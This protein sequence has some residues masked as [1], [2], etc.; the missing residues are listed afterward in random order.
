MTDKTFTNDI[1]ISSRIRLARNLKNECFPSMA[2]DMQL[3]NVSNLV[4]D[5][6]A[7]SE[8]LVSQKFRFYE[9]QNM[10]ETQR[11]SLAESRLISSELGKHAHSGAMINDENSMSIMINE[12]DHIRIQ[13]IT[14]GF[15]LFGAYRKA[16]AADDILQD[17]LDIAFSEKYGFLTCCPTNLGTGMRAGVMVHI[18]AIIMQNN[19][20]NIIKIAT[21]SG[22]EIRGAYGE[23]SVA[24]G[25]L[26]QISNRVSLGMN[27]NEIVHS[28]HEFT[29]EVIKTERQARNQLL[30]TREDEIKNE[31]HRAYGILTHAHMISTEEAMKLLSLLRLGTDVNLIDNVDPKT[32]DRLMTEIQPA[33][34]TLRYRIRTDA[35]SRDLLR[36]QH[37]KTALNYR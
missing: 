13:A 15:D 16:E 4:S 10:T 22:L 2:T 33:T 7:S 5:C 37:I 25:D 18:P 6:V 14:Q 23:G 24:M 31:V 8:K 34:L 36:A 32:V 29:K 27:E 35:K 20:S 26:F 12:E 17:K 3:L 19:L 1:A 30:I 11:Q 21:A 9:I 28:I